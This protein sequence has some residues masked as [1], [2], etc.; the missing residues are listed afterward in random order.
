MATTF[1]RNVGNGFA[2]DAASYARLKKPSATPLKTPKLEKHSPIQY[3][4]NWLH[5]YLHVR[6]EFSD[7]VEWV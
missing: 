3:S 7:Y 2:A 4:Y 1:L 6:K 5:S